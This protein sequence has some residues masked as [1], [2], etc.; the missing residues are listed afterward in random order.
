MLY[1]SFPKEDIHSANDMNSIYEQRLY[2]KI[3]YNW[4]KNKM[5]WDS[6]NTSMDYESMN[7]DRTYF[8]THNI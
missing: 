2:K 4:E 6:S 5:K 3:M 8:I 7:A 1:I